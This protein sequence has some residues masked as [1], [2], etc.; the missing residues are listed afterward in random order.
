MHMKFGMRTPN[1]KKSFKA[2]MTVK[3]KLAVKKDRQRQL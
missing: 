3:A 1:S 2:R